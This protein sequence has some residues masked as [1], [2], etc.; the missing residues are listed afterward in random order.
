L[1]SVIAKVKPE[2]I[3]KN[4]MDYFVLLAMTR[5][6]IASGINKKFN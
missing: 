4:G 5:Q 3:H 2:A 6:G 1:F